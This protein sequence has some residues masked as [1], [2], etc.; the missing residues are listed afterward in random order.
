M[1]YLPWGDRRPSQPLI[2]PT[3]KRVKT[4]QP[5]TRFVAP[6]RLTGNPE[7]VRKIDHPTSSHSQI[8][9]DQ[10]LKGTDETAENEEVKEVITTTNESKTP[11]SA[12]TSSEGQVDKEITDDLPDP[13]TILEA[14]QALHQDFIK[15]QDNLDEFINEAEAR[16]AKLETSIS[17]STR[18][19]DE[20]KCREGIQEIKTLMADASNSGS[21]R[22]YFSAF[23]FNGYENQQSRTRSHLSRFTELDSEDESTPLSAT[24]DPSLLQVAGLTVTP[25]HSPVTSPDSSSQVP[26]SSQIQDPDEDPSPNHQELEF[27]D[28]IP[29][30]SFDEDLNSDVD[31]LGPDDIM[32][33]DQPSPYR[34]SSSV[35][36]A[37]SC[38]VSIAN[39]EYLGSSPPPSASP[40]SPMQHQ[41]LTQD[42]EATQSIPSK[43][44]I[45][46]AQPTQ[47]SQPTQVPQSSQSP[48][49]VPTDPRTHPKANKRPRRSATLPSRPKP[50]PI[51]PPAKKQK[52]QKGTK[53]PYIKGEKGSLPIGTLKKSDGVAR[54]KGAIWPKLGPNTVI[55]LGGYIE[56]EAVRQSCI[57]KIETKSRLILVFWTGTPI[58]RGIVG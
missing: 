44:P 40:P 18:D 3:M 4:S 50:A 37:A 24:I 15:H 49:S 6:R 14:V 25:G 10:S 19:E 21:A 42:T 54:V 5:L 33:S 57:H 1:Q 28:S 46:S 45:P 48:L 7:P 56:C 34:P 38:L 17:T 16:I 23:S 58:L 30:P 26:P 13:S 36:A 9:D 55:G 31:D 53:K 35:A 41:E 39:S 27:P 20:D 29:A 51:Q 52:G 12:E 8:E 43:Q 22:V 2:I 11:N 47:I 32:A